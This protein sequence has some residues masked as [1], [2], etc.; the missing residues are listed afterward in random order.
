MKP[1]CSGCVRTGQPCIWS[2]PDPPP[3]SSTP[4]VGP[5]ACTDP[6][7]ALN[8]G[9]LSNLSGVAKYV[10]K[11]YWLFTADTLVKG[12]STDGNPF[13]T[14][15]LPLA[16]SDELVMD[17]VLALGG[18]H[19]SVND[20]NAKHLEVVTRSH[21]ASVLAGLRHLINQDEFDTPTGKIRVLVLLL[22]LCVFE[23]VQGNTHGA[24]YHH[25]KA[26]H[27]L[28]TSL[29][30]APN[31]D[32]PDAVQHLRGFILEL[33]VFLALK[34][35][36]TPRA[37]LY[38]QS[39]DL[40][41]FL[42]SLGFL[43]KFKSC[44]FMLGFG[45]N[46]FE[47]IPAVSQLVQQRYLQEQQGL[48]VTPSLHKSYQD[49]LES[50]RAIV[51][52]LDEDNCDHLRPAHERAAATVLYRNALVIYLHAAFHQDLLLDPVLS[53]EIATRVQDSID[54]FLSLFSTQGPLRRMLLWPAMMI[55]SCCRLER[56]IKGF[57]MAL[58]AGERTPGGVKE[59]ARLIEVGAF[60][61]SQNVTST[62]QDALYNIL[63]VVGML[64]TLSPIFFLEKSNHIMPHQSRIV[65]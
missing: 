49:T 45:H 44:G 37:C 4:A 2:I 27:S 26:S 19:L 56:H 42:Q 25:I 29:A 14:Y 21:Y 7:P 10:Y 11:Q 58:N 62:A 5:Q 60:E 9:T 50:L 31:S 61:A 40:D 15:V 35:S 30:T 59:A 24:I 41:P 51:P 3:I 32:I 55:A 54:P 16:A 38:E 39:I 63:S 46:V 1:I 47:A 52:S 53:A 8:Y 43:K 6:Q 34:L 65:T 23:G 48:S 57:R 13:I 33:Y 20:V 36:V 12:P 17:I 28:A 64:P 18:A 22:L